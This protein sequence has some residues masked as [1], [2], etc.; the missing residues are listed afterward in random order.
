VCRNCGA[1]VGAGEQECA[2]CG[3]NVAASAAAQDEA[4]QRLHH[5]RD[6]MRF[7]RAILT[8]PATFTFAFII[9]NVFVFL[10]TVLAA[11]GS[12]GEAGF[13]PVLIAY[14]AK[15]NSYINAGQWWRFVTP[16]FLHGSIAHLLMNMYG[17]WILGPYVER[18][19][20]SAKFVVFWV[21]SGIA[22]V[23]ASYLT[24]RPETHAGGPVGRFLFKAEDLAS[25]G[26]SGA[27][28]GL[29][30]V[31]F[32]FGIKFRH[33]L[34]EG[35]K[36]AFGTGMLPTI[37]LNVFIGYVFP[38]IDNAAHMGG[39]MAGA[40]LALFVGYK[41]P[42]EPAGVAIFWHILQVGALALVLFSFFMVWRTYTG[43]PINF[44]NV[45]VPQLMPDAKASAFGSNLNAIN[46][47]QTAFVKAMNQGDASDLDRAAEGLD[48]AP[49]LDDAT[50]ALR[51]ELKSLLARAKE[52]TNAAPQQPSRPSR[53]QQRAREDER[54]K[55][56]ADFVAWNKKY[57]EWAEA[58][59]RK[60]GVKLKEPGPVNDNSSSGK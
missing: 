47:A 6:A 45:S 26:A 32:V 40:V 50:D 56:F 9:A 60:Y 27:L 46:E 54:K 25:V 58:D 51:N 37:L 20:G 23:V 24:V 28:F 1:L 35:F 42:H 7:A 12:V 3:A 11:G 21:L 29:I 13:T 8:R 10:L 57:Q 43:P 31:L 34:P 59:S 18:L 14:G 15:L 33:E 36:R 52:F 17:L 2:Q 5:D 22:G 44:N 48:A 49:R 55:L 16:I 38:F 30:G 41:R 19:Y 4:Q 53:Q 39:L